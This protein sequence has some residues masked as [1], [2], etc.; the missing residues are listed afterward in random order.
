MCKMP[1]LYSFIK[2]IIEPYVG[3][4]F[5]RNLSY[6]TIHKLMF[7][8]GDA[9]SRMESKQRDRITSAAVVYITEQTYIFAWF[10]VVSIQ[11]PNKFF[12]VCIHHWSWCLFTAHYWHVLL[13]IILPTARPSKRP[14]TKMIPYQ[15]SVRIPCFPIVLTCPAH[16]SLLEFIIL[17]IP[18][19]LYK[20]LPPRYHYPNNT[21]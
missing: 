14:F 12:A 5:V 2:G 18:G 7:K 15:N 6:S 4:E 20:Q 8:L 21:R 3:Y 9:W 11:F 10:H 17:T 13:N 19:D 1:L 16:R